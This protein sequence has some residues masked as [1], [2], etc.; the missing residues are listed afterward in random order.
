MAVLADPSPAVLLKGA[1]AADV[2]V[3]GGKAA[4]LARLAA[5]FRV[6]AFFVIP[7][8][9]F[10]E[11][12]LPAALKAE[13]ADALADI[14]AGPYAVRSSGREEDGESGS[15]AGQFAT[16]L[17]IAAHDVTDA[18]FRV[19]RSG[20]TETLSEYRIAKGLSGAP[21]PPSVL[22]QQMIAPR[23]AGVAFSADPVSGDRSIAVIS[24][25]EG[26]ADRLVGGDE[27]GDSYRID[28]ADKTVDVDLVGPNPV[29]SEEERAEVAAL[30][31]AAQAHFGS[32]QD[33]EW[34]IDGAGL[35]LLQ[36]R[37]ITTLAPLV[38]SS[39][40]EIVIW[41]NSN[42]VESYP[43][44]VSPLTFTFARYVYSHVY[45]AFSRMMGVSRDAV[46]DHRAVFENMLGRVDGRVYY[47]LLNW[48]RALAL[49]P[50]FKANRAFMEG[51]MGVSEA[52][53][54][55]LAEK[56]AP[57]EEDGFARFLDNLALVRVGLGLVY[58]QITIR[59]TID[60]FYERL[61]AALA[62]PDAEIDRMSAPALAAQYRE[63]EG[64]L[65]ARWDA[66]LVNDFLCMI[67]FGAAQKAVTKWGGDEGVAHLSGVLIGQG[68]I[69]SA[70]PAKLIR[71]MGEIA[72]P[73]PVL[74]A[75]LGAGD[76][77]AVSM[78]PELQRRFDAYI[79]K[80]GDRCTQELKL[81]S[82]TLHDDPT[83]ILKAVAAAAQ[84][85]GRVASTAQVTPDIEDVI[86]DP[87]Q[88]IVARWLVSWAK[89]RVRD[90]ENL[91]FERTRLFGRVRRIVLALGSRFNEAG[92]L[93][94]PRDVFNLTIEELLG[95]VEGALVTADLRR[96]AA[97]RAAETQAQ[98]LRPDPPERFTVQGAH[99]SGLS[100]LNAAASA[101]DEGGDVRKGLGC[102][103]G[104][105][106]AKVRVIEDPRVEA[107]EPGE[108]LVARHTDPGWIAVFANAAGVIAERGS[109]LSH[110]AIVAREMGV[111]CVVGLKNATQWLKTGDIV[112]L[113]GGAGT[114][115]RTAGAD[116]AQA[117]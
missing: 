102:C 6:P 10:T 79:A 35:H 112:R 107:L 82:R 19:W 22:V 29:L 73:D 83:Q 37:P 60:S 104:V 28:G 20:F 76:R 48:Y 66:P 36:S 18:A 88:R 15:H 4:A 43:G 103:R 30:A 114:V 45:Q 38:P 117:G 23:A 108:I 116:P 59:P 1:D 94:D 90:R 39:D 58:R 42:I 75:R 97:L 95:A 87:F 56:I 2:A 105:I 49:F 115:E 3:A 96:L 100:A 110:S 77:S 93:D 31:R 26:L 98:L 52:L 84:S 106:T 72:A 65:L 111:P 86:D 69:I 51:M 54:E 13:I 78:S 67:A 80:F 53:P 70:E 64:R 14:G 92:V 5:A 50:G 27:D 17:N 99:V 71:E 109:L 12:G 9:A 55:A 57:K 74:V 32:P 7:A 63:L 40:D 11:Q 24:A 68:D 44:V 46:E 16:E 91:R 85:T 113:D 61:N 81:E 47:N 62:A 34:A 33:I 89:A 8:D 25:V 21:H 41:D 101:P